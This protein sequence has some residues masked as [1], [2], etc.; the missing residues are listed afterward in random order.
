MDA[1]HRGAILIRDKRSTTAKTSPT[2][3]TIAGL[4]AGGHAPALA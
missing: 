1:H 2:S 4:C 3:P